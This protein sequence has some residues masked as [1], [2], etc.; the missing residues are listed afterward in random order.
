MLFGENFAGHIRT[1]NNQWVETRIISFIIPFQIPYSF[2]VIGVER[3]KGRNWKTG[4]E[5]KL[6][7]QSVFALFL[8]AFIHIATLGA[9]IISI[10]HPPLLIIAFLAL[11]IWVYICFI[12]GKTPASEMLIREAMFRTTGYSIMPEW[13]KEA[14]VNRFHQVTE[15]LYH[16]FV[17]DKTHIHLPVEEAYIA[18]AYKVME[19][20]RYGNAS[21]NVVI[22]QLEQLV[23][24]HFY[25]N[26]K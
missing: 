21:Y 4:L 23:K 26:K 25:F 24:P 15:E 7:K 19:R 12:F 3:G 10:I 14:D 1:Q 8:R 13:L 6:V 16:R 9:I 22:N 18:L 2:F 20:R 5:L 17:K 11:T